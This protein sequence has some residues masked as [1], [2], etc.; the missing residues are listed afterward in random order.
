MAALH[1]V[2]NEYLPLQNFN[3]AEIITLETP[4]LALLIG[5][6]LILKPFIKNTTAPKLILYILHVSF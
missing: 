4:F 6:I 3:F 5:A 2:L 1:D